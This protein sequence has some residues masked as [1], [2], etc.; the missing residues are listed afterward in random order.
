MIKV[1]I[2]LL[3]RNHH[4]TTNMIWVSSDNDFKSILQKQ[5]N[6]SLIILF[7]HSTRCPVSS[8]AYQEVL[9]FSEVQSDDYE[10]IGINVITDRSFSQFIANETGIRHES[11]Q[12][13]ISRNS[14]VLANFSHFQ[15]TNEKL[16]Q[17]VNQFKIH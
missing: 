12:I 13:I 9:K 6:D 3:K 1:I 15:I 4:K 16:I 8:R 17:S 5:D 14:K 7:K 11:P 10:I 2:N